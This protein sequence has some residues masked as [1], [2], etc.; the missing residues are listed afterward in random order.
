MRWNISDG[1]K[2]LVRT[3]STLTKSAT[4]LQKTPEGEK[5]FPLTVPNK[6]MDDTKD[7]YYRL[8]PKP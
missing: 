6:A 8:E 5:L 3:M 1:G 4:Y 7:L 2:T